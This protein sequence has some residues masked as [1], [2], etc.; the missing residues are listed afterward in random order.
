METSWVVIDMMHQYDIGSS[1]LLK[2]TKTQNA[3]VDGLAKY[4]GK[5]QEKKIIP[6]TN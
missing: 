2:T 1:S 4:R 6:I 5:Q 3:F